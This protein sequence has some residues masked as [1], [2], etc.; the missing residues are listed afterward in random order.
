MTLPEAC[1]IL[2]AQSQSGRGFGVRFTKKNGPSAPCVYRYITIMAVLQ[3]TKQCRRDGPVRQQ[4]P[5][6][7]FRGPRPLLRLG[8]RASRPPS[9]SS[10]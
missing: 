1:A 8:R 5:L 10:A 2:Q 7:I 4:F 6:R 3:M 9:S